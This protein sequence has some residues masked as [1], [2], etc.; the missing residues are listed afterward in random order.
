MNNH[1]QISP[2][3]VFNLPDDIPSIAKNDP[4]V[5]HYY[6]A[7]MGAFSGKS[8]LN[9]NAISLVLSGEKTLHFAEKRVQIKADE[10]HFL[11][12]G[13]CLVSMKLSESTPFKSILLFF[14][15]SVLSNF[16]VKYQHRIHQLNSKQPSGSE[17]YLFF[18]KDP[19]VLNYITSLLLLL[20]NQTPL[21]G[22]MKQ[23]KFEELMLHL[24]EKY[25]A[26]ILAFQTKKNK[27]FDDLAIRK[28]VETNIT[29][30]LKLEDLAFLCNTSLS[31]FKRRFQ[32]IYA[33][34]P[35]KW[36]LQQRMALAKELLEHHAT[37]PSEVYYQVG[38]E[39]HSSFSQAFKQ[40]FGLSP[41]EFQLQQLNETQQL[42]T[43]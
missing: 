5:F 38:Y 42:L 29:S 19:F 32:K 10:F 3:Q 22:E 9:K 26:Q 12:T 6:S 33:L 17:P 30:H 15:D 13:N 40:S 1:S 28:V 39:N 11:S 25:P 43:E 20:H 18:K 24:L 36:L 34:A 35:N 23:L 8:V 4:V 7:P 16:Y 2:Q 31:T 41:K 14:D 37:K 27:N 21:S